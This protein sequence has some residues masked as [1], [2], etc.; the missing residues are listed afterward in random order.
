VDFDSA[1]LEIEEWSLGPVV[2]KSRGRE[3]GLEVMGECLR[4]G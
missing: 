3:L 2:P 1:V 4:E